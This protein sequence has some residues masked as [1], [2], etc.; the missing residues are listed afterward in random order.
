MYWN[1]GTDFGP[2]S[3][4]D[5]VI[6]LNKSSQPLVLV[7]SLKLVT[8]PHVSHNCYLQLL[9]LVTILHLSHNILQTS[10]VT[11]PHVTLCPFEKNQCD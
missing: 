4:I 6:A 3:F 2:K 5:N 8:S 1:Y 11:A 9:M 10:L 7:T